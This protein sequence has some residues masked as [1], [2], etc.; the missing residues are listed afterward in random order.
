TREID[1]VEE[2]ARF[3]LEDVP[4]RLPQRQ[5]MFG[6][7]TKAQRIRRRIQDTLAGFGYSEAY[8][9]SLLPEE[10]EPN[11]VHLQ[12]PLS[13]EQAV[14]RTSLLQGLIASARRNVDVGNEDIAL[15]ELAHV[16]LPTGEQ[17]P[18]EPWHVGGIVE[19]GFGLAK[20][21]VEG[22]YD[23]LGVDP[24]FEPVADLNGRGRGARTA[25]G[26]VLALREPELP[27]DWGAFELDVDRLVERVPDL[28]V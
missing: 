7:L 28:V 20:G 6:R 25:D 15:F 10:K 4:T 22:L 2:V 5:A 16:Y 8:S 27:G 12:E 18:D 1:V 19:G 21:A 11:G 23:A 17:L 24:V 9:W 14:L 3:R 13:S 26:W